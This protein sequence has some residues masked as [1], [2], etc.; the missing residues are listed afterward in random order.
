MLLVSSPGFIDVRV[1]VTIGRLQAT[2]TPATIEPLVKALERPP[3]QSPGDTEH[4]AA[5]HAATSGH[6]IFRWTRIH[7]E[8]PLAEGPVGPAVGPHPAG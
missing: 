6:S 2:A 4:S 7:A 8:D 3:P 5:R 1:T